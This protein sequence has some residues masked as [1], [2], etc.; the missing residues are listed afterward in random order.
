MSRPMSTRD[1]LHSERR[2]AVAMY[3]LGF[4]RF[5]FLRIQTGELVLDPWPT[6]VR[7]VKFASED[8]STS[9]TPPD[10]FELKRQVTELFEYVRAVEAGEIRCL[11]VRHGLPFSMEVEHRPDKDRGSRG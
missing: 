2:F 5:E 6:T 10:E 8:Q 9:R 1:L 3:G 7:G 4:G 11:E